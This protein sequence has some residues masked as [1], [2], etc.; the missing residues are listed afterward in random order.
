MF[1]PVIITVLVHIVNFWE[2]HNSGFLK[3]FGTIVSAKNNKLYYVLNLCF[4]FY[5]N[6]KVLYACIRNFWT[7]FILF[8]VTINVAVVAQRICCTIQL[9]SVGK[10]SFLQLVLFHQS[11]LT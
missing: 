6:I 10:I 8:L 4:F 9:L 1:F 5:D 2:K 11:C 7:E 3:T